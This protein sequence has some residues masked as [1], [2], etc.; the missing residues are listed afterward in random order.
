MDE[1]LDAA[2]D[3]IL[4]VLLHG[5][6]HMPN[7]AMSGQEHVELLKNL[8]MLSEKAREPKAVEDNLKK[9]K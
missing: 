6:I 2:I 7:G 5:R 1:K 4:Q 9:G 3:N 8:D